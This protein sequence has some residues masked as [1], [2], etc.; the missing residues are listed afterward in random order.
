MR[1]VCATG[2]T[3]RAVAIYVASVLF[4]TV[5]SAAN[6][7]AVEEILK[8]KNA[9]IEDE[10]IVAFIESKNVNYDLSAEDILSLRDKGLSSAVIKA[11]LASGRGQQT[12]TAGA[13]AQ[14]APPQAQPPPPSAP[15]APGNDQMQKNTGSGS[16]SVPPPPPTI[17]PPAKPQPTADPDVAFF[18]EA[19]VPYGRWILLDDGRW[20]WQ[21]FV[22]IKSV[23]W[24][25]YWDKGYWVWTDHGWYWYSEYPWGW[26]VFHYGRWHLHPVHGWVWFPD[27][28][29]GPAWVIWRTGPVYCGWAPLP[30]GVVYD[31][32]SGRFLYHGRHVTIGFDFGLN[33]GHFSFCYVHEL[34]KPSRRMIGSDKSRDAF[35]QT[36]VVL[37]YSVER[38][39]PH[40]HGS[41]DY[42]VINHG[43]DPVRANLGKNLHVET[44][45]VQPMPHP[46]KPR[47]HEK[48]DPRRKTISV[49]RP[50]HGGPAT[51]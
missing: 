51:R 8:L 45:Q 43:I 36:T 6:L 23:A 2:F 14:T 5:A 22:A 35:Y 46:E 25:P 7:A 21:P 10:T 47:V 30:P 33:W 15:A 18:Y 16:S 1:T 9:G 27:R 34:G 50:A 24:R 37:N 20:C 4:S 29:W 11:M 38:S 44:V 12:T 17:L 13:V 32:V 31:T 40:S 49:Y 48:F 3:K 19:L 39:Q 42:K 26:A 41:P 28:V